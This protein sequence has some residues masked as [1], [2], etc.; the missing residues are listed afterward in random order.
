MTGTAAETEALKESL[1]AD[2]ALLQSKRRERDHLIKCDEV[3][4]KITSRGKTRAELEGLD[5]LHHS[6][7]G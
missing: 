7:V 5:I 6:D 3:A 4:A 2:Q 1:K